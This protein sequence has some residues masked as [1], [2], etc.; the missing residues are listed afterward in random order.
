VT[1]VDGILA[2]AGAALGEQLTGAQELGR[3]R[4]LV[5]RARAGERTVVLKA[6]LETGPG[7]AREL[8]ALR[9]VRGLPGVL[10]LLAEAGDP[11]VLV[12][13]DL[14]SGPSVA[15]AL[16]GSDPVAAE[17]ALA[18]WATALGTL[19]AATTERSGAFAAELASLYPLGRLE[20]DTS[21]GTLTSTAATL[22]RLL[23]RLGVR[24]SADAVDELR[25][26]P[27]PSAEAA[28]AVQSTARAVRRRACSGC[29]TGIGRPT[30]ASS[31]PGSSTP[32]ASHGGGFRWPASGS[33]AGYAG[34]TA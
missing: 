7:P 10:P 5:L 26:L 9:T 15:D 27:P 11:P 28:A 13:A 18:A 20:P 2:A 16:L 17:E 24:P 22:D 34:R 12:L 31:R 4:S 29:R 14:G 30:A 21:A 23:P 6:P 3:G 33:P 8:A 19:Q 32:V 25:S 1:L